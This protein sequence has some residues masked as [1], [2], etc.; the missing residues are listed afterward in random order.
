VHSS[1]AIQSYMM[2]EMGEKLGTWTTDISYNPADIN[3]ENLKKYDA[4]LLDSTTGCFLDQPGDKAATDARRAALLA[5]VREGKGLGGIHASTDS[6]HSACPNDPPNPNA[7]G[8]RGGNAAAAG[9][10]AQ[11]AAAIVPQ[12]DKNSDQKLTLVEMTTLA[13]EWFDKMDTDKTGRIA[14]ADFAARYAAAQP[15]ALPGGRGAGAGANAGA[16]P[17]ARGS[18]K[19]PAASA[20]WPEW[21]K[22]IGG[23]FKFHWSTARTS[24]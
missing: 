15:P 24:P 9:P 7:T 8:G 3:T 17:V 2:K 1:I 14:Q 16:V 22:V 11:F 13:N 23:Y 20:S 4:V 5:F 6:Y 12:A 10:G 19:L 18:T 21:T